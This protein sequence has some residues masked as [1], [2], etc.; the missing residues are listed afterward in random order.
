MIIKEIQNKSDIHLFYK[1]GDLAYRGNKNQR[2]TEFS[3]VKM[4]VEKKT[5]FYKHADIKLFLILE[6]NIP[7]GRF[8]LIRDLKLK[9]YVQVSFFELIKPIHIEKQIIQLSKKHFPLSPKLAIGLNAHLNYSIGFLLNKFDRP[10]L[11]GLPYTNEFY[12]NLF[13]S[14]EKKPMVTFRFNN[15]PFVRFLKSV[16]TNNQIKIRT[17]NK[18]KLE[19]DISIYTKLNNDCFKEHPFW[20]DRE[21]EE[22]MELFKDFKLIMKNNNLLIAE[23]RGKPIGFLLWYPDFNKLVSSNEQIGVKQFLRFKLFNPLTKVRLTEI[24]ILPEYRGKGIAELLLKRFAK[25]IEKEKYTHTEV[26]FIFEENLASMGLSFKMMEKVLGQKIEPYRRYAV[27][28][29]N[30]K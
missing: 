19:E 5:T 17:M 24:G 23:D 18:K 15:D 13:P 26:G 3:L 30:L 10:P 8:A 6:D 2:S 11:F 9:D 29:T 16:P 20:A 21:V 22:D 7:I 28:T 12:I 25:E 4:L 1:I 27:F 14:F